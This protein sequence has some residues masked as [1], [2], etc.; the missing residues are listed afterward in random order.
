[1]ATNV[2]SFG[3][4]SKQAGENI[5][6]WVK[7]VT[8][9]TAFAELPRQVAKGF[10]NE[11]IV[12]TDGVPR[13]DPTLVKPFGKIEF[14]ARTN[15]A[16]MVT[17]ALAE[18]IKRSPVLTGR[19]KASHVVML[20]GTAV[21]ANQAAA[22]RAA[23]PGDRVQIVNTV[24]YAK[25]IEGQPASRRRGRARVRGQSRKA[26][27]GVYRVVQRLAVSRYGR[28]VFVDFKYVKLD[29]GV[30]VWG[31]QGGGRNRK[32]VQRAAVYP[33]LQFFIKDAGVTVH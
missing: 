14:V 26:P 8:I 24:P 18:L 23:K 4:T 20:N 5:S 21:G 13:R 17:W 3:L 31:F 6:Q 22:L 25:K 16:E 29:T 33:A 27:G 1:M 10:D 9:E 32:R 15:Y 12:I 2:V 19:Y 11:P 28:S 7:R 30:K